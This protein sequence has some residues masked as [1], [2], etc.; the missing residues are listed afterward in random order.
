[1]H[2]QKT[3]II[4]DSNVFRDTPNLQP[5]WILPYA[6]ELNLLERLNYK[7]STAVASLMDSVDVFY[8]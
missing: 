4:A 7:L 6:D 1:M 2:V 5:D 8:N 3:Y